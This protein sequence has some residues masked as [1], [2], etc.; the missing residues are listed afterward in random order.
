MFYSKVT[1]NVFSISSLVSEDIDDVI[2]RFLHWIYI[3]KTKITRWLE[4]MNV[5]FLW[6]KQYLFSSLE[7][8]I[9]I[10]APPCNILSISVPG[11]HINSPCPVSLRGGAILGVGDSDVVHVERQASV[12]INQSR[13]NC[14]SK[15]ETKKRE[16]KRSFVK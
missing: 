13:S 6:W 12:A 3:V 1:S 9:H 5:I 7:D 14:R 2:S 10:F 4:D 11:L 8:K 15:T 16:E